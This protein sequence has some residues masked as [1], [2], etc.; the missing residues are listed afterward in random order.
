MLK[1]VIYARI[2]TDDRTVENQL[3]YAVLLDL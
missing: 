1:A 2:S 3:K